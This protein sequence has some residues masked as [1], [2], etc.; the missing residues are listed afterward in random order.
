VNIAA[1]IYSG[2]KLLLEKHNNPV[3]HKLF[4]ENL[5]FIWKNMMKVPAQRKWL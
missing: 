4:F 2:Y 3:N 5:N 1:V